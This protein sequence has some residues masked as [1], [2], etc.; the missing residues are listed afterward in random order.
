M[1]L[2][3]SDVLRGIRMRHK[4]FH[5]LRVPDRVLAEFLADYQNQLIA[6]GVRRDK[7]FLSQSIA[8]ALALETAN[9]PGVAGVGTSGGLPADAS[10]TP[11]TIEVV[12]EPA[13]ALIE[14]IDTVADGRQVHVAERRV[15]AATSTSVT[16]SGAGR[17]V[18]A[19]ALRL[20]YITGG[21]GRGQ[22]REILS[23][24]TDTW[25]VSDGT[26]GKEWEVTPDE[27]STLEV[28]VANLTA[29]EARGVVT[30]LPAESARTGYLV[31]LNAAGVPYIDYTQP[32][33]VTVDR[34]VPLPTLV[35]LLGG[36]VRFTDAAR[37][38]EPLHITTYNHRFSA[39]APAV[40]L[41][42]ETLVLCGDR[43]DWRDIRSLELRY[44][45]HAPTFTATNEYF[46]LPDP[47]RGALV[48]QGAAFAACRVA[49]DK[50]VTIDRRYLEEQGARAEERYLDTLS[51]LRGARVGPGR[52][53]W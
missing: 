19:D 30:D 49:D 48:A 13:G 7:Q 33:T 23:N 47:A 53:D 35:A 32:L 12:Q 46:L 34:G 44:V 28:L 15:T 11:D 38:P 4:A 45:P 36:T 1:S 40:Y 2:L 31:R 8:I 39:V 14:V 16:S 52:E 27:T 9:E 10:V 37:A 3:L 25:V 22:Y 5:R 17:T 41:Q 18:N 21:L 50:D 24:T 20:V 42:G 6:E 43:E 26:D 51:T 29:T